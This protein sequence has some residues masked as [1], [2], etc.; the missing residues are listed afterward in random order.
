MKSLIA[1]AI[2]ALGLS[3]GLVASVNSA[4]AKTFA[5]TVFE[6]KGP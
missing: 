1:L 6:P 2:L 4:S 5:E 3:A